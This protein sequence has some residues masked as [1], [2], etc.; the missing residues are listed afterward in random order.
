MARNH[1][2][3]KQYVE[4]LGEDLNKVYELVRQNRDIT[5]DKAKWR[6]D[7]K[8]KPMRYQVGD[9]C[10]KVSRT[11]KIGL[12]RK[13]TGPYRI[14]ELVSDENYLIR[15]VDEENRI[16][17]RSRCERV[18][19]NNLKKYYARVNQE[20]RLQADEEEIATTQQSIGVPQRKVHTSSPIQSDN[21]VSDV[22]VEILVGGEHLGGDNATGL[23][24]SELGETNMEPER[25][26]D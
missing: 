1:K 9:L 16:I 18:H 21:R 19:H 14:I 4:E 26:D 20:C 11:Q 25:S 23:N 2:L 15:K 3:A 22:L 10:L 8:I 7:R 24:E 17:F 12:T 5:M 13:T 6:H